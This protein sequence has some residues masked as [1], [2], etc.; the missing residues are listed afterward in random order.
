MMHPNMLNED[1][2][3]Q[4]HATALT[5]PEYPV[6]TKPEYLVESDSCLVF[7]ASAKRSPLSGV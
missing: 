6:V 2:L 3:G 5:K 4:K 7:H 1:V